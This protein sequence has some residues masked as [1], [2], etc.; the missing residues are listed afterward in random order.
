MLP[1]R[2]D[3]NSAKD[4]DR[5]I[6]ILAETVFNLPV[7]KGIARPL[8]GSLGNAEMLAFHCGTWKNDSGYG[9]IVCLVLRKKRF[10]FILNRTSLIVTRS[11]LP[12]DTDLVVAIRD[13]AKTKFNIDAELHPDISQHLQ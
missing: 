11:I 7:G 6:N 5:E 8:I 4:L 3:I 2:R 10:I 1:A 13:H 12:E 9:S